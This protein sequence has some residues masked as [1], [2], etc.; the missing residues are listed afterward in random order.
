MAELEV[1][2]HLFTNQQ[3]LEMIKESVDLIQSGKLLKI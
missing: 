2:G 3:T 1:P